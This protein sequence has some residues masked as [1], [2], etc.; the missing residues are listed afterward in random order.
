MSDDIR[1]RVVIEGSV[2]PMRRHLSGPLEC[3][4]MN[5]QPPGP[6]A[7]NTLMDML[8]NQPTGARVRVTV[9]VLW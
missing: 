9:E 2:Q 1:Y 6:P 4:H 3:I 7:D 5:V 8:S